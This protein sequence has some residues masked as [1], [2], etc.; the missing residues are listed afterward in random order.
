MFLAV[1]ISQILLFQYGPTHVNLFGMIFPRDI[2]NDS[3]FF[4]A[5]FLKISLLETTFVDFSPS[6]CEEI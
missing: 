2:E 5:I 3:K 6:I 4:A 1:K